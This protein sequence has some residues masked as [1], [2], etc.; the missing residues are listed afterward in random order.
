MLKLAAEWRRCGET[1]AFTN[2]VFDLTLHPGHIYLLESAAQLADRLVVGVNGDAS[3]RRLGKGPGRPRLPEQTRAANVAAQDMVD[4]VLIFN[5][6]TP[7]ELLSEL[8]PDFLVKGDEYRPEEVAGRE[9]AGRVVL[10]PRLKGY[11]TTSLDEKF[12]AEGGV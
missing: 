6:P 9:Y 4:M 1:I 10:I 12:S 2:G 11:S 8:R 7:R 3:A 5:E